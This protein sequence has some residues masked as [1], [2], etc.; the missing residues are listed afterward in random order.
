MRPK[1]GILI[2]SSCEDGTGKGCAYDLESGKC[3]FAF[4]IE[5]TTANVINFISVCLAIHRSKGGETFY[6]NNHT[7]MVW[8]RTKYVKT[9]HGMRGVK[10]AIDFLSGLDVESDSEA[11][12]IN[13]GEACVKKWNSNDWGKVKDLY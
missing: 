13:G 11:I 2:K 7:A 4:Q 3:L 6:T 8:L 5:D 9:D 1:E 10:W 12:W